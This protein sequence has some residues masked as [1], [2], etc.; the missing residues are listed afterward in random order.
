MSTAVLP[1]TPAAVDVDEGL[2]W[3]A[4]AQPAAVLAFDAATLER[5]RVIELSGEPADLALVDGRL[6]VALR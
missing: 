2:V 1:G 5:V 3:V 6:V 4:I